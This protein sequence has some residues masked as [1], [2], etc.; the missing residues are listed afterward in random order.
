M[1]VEQAPEKVFHA[2]RIVGGS[3]STI[4]R[5]IMRGRWES[6]ISKITLMRQGGSPLLKM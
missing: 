1:V 3:S 6:V 4:I 2:A 5:G